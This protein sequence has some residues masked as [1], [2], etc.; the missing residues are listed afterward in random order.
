MSALLFDLALAGS[1]YPPDREEYI[2]RQVAELLGYFPSLL[3][4]ANFLVHNRI[5]EVSGTVP[6]THR[7]FK[8]YLPI[9]LVLPHGFPRAPPYVSVRPTPDMVI[10]Y[11]H[12]NVAGNGQVMT[13]Y[14]SQVCCGGRGKK[15]KR[16]TGLQGKISRHG[17]LLLLLLFG[18]LK[19]LMDAVAAEL[20]SCG[21]GSNDGDC[22]RG[23]PTALP[24]PATTPCTATPCTT[25]ATAAAIASV[26]KPAKIPPIPSILPGPWPRTPTVPC[27]IR[28]VESTSPPSPQLSRRAAPIIRPVAIRLE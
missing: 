25:T 11:Q 19:F 8:Y 12:P 18:F 20:E 5:I 6:M 14:L 1:G 4:N 15:R 3:L 10:K 13:P 22:I 24:A 9:G 17:P 2:A 26:C 21:S 7:G 23:Q 28:A 27:T 16:L